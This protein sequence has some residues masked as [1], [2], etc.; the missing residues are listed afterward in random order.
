M[1]ENIFSKKLKNSILNTASGEDGL[2]RR[3]DLFLINTN[4]SDY[5]K[6]NLIQL[7][8]EVYLVH[9]NDRNEEVSEDQAS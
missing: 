6:A 9:T 7:F 5:D 2:V 3:I 4:L 8:D 1:E